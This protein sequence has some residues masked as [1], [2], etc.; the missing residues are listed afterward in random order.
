MLNDLEYAKHYHKYFYTVKA[1]TPELRKIGYQ[2]RYKV[3]IEECKYNFNTYNSKD[4]IERDEYDDDALHTLL[5]HKPTNLAI[6]YVRLIPYSQRLELLPMEKY[7][8]IHI[9]D[10]INLVDTLRSKKTGEVSRM[11]LLSSFRQRR[12]DH[13]FLAG[14]LELEDLP[15]DRRFPINYLAL[16]LTLIG[17]NLLFEA[18]LDCSVAF[19]ERQLASLIR[20]FGIQH[21]QIGE[22]IDYCGHRA[23]YLIFPQ[24]TYDHLTPEV[25]L[26]YKQ[27]REELESSAHVTC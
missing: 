10:G 9:N 18:D 27:I 5:F 19:M 4:K 7:G 22:F 16:C 14:G 12:F 17:T 11:C 3:F 2:L 24:K 26:L 1:D 15:D 8:K 6:G 13:A 20:K 23:P 25:L 21:R